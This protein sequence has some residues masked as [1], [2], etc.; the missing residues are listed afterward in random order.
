MCPLKDVRSAILV[1][2]IIKV[3]YN[4]NETK[5][6]FTTTRIDNIITIIPSYPY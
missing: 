6:Y 5:A 4:L 1:S 2:S 3:K